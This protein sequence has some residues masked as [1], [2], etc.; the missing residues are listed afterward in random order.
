MKQTPDSSLLHFKTLCAVP[1][2]TQQTT[3]ETGYVSIRGWKGKEAC[4][5]L[6]L[7]G[8]AS[9]NPWP[10]YTDCGSPIRSNSMGISPPSHQKTETYPVS[11]QCKIQKPS[12]PSCNITLSKPYG[13]KTVSR[14]LSFHGGDCSLLGLT[15]CSLIA[16]YWYCKG[17][18]CFHYQGR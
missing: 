9:V 5:E 12:N 10:P 11:K 3:L 14:D 4:T 6:R 1:K 16:S 13:I 2:A 17:A 18:Y 8:K 7:T 15:S